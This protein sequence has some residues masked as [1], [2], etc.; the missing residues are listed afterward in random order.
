LSFSLTINPQPPHKALFLSGSILLHQRS[1]EDLRQILAWNKVRDRF[2]DKTMWN[3]TSRKR[4]SSLLIVNIQMLWLAKLFAVGCENDA[5]ALCFAG[6]LEGNEDEICRA[7]DLGDA[8]AQA[9]V[10]G[11]FALERIF[12]AR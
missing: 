3:W 1:P 7:A 11:E 9:W 10:A 12:D 6:V 4:W 2:W 8:F 5:R